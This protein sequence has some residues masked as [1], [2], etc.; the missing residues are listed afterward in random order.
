MPVLWM[1]IAGLTSSR[2]QPVF[3]QHLRLWTVWRTI[4]LI[5]PLRV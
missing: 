4:R 3:E 2:A 1:F 5:V